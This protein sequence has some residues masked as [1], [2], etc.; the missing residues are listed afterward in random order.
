MVVGVTGT[1]LFNAIW[2]R[3]GGLGVQ[4]SVFVLFYE[5]SGASKLSMRD[6]GLGFFIFPSS[7]LTAWVSRAALSSSLPSGM[8]PDT[9][10]PGMRQGI[11]RMTCMLTAAI[12]AAPRVAAL[13]V[14]SLLALLVPKYKY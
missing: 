4:V 12:R 1:G 9:T 10:S 14:L 13:Q 7:F 6:G 11:T 2:M 5:W 3:D 8:A